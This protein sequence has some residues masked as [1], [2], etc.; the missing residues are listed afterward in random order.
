MDTMS[1]PNR[2]IGEFI[3]EMTEWCVNRRV[4]SDTSTLHDVQVTSETLWEFIGW[5]Q[6]PGSRERLSGLLGR[7]GF[8]P[9]V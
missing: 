8:N 3:I 7:A 6:L 4:V 5:L 9:D 1:E 2:E